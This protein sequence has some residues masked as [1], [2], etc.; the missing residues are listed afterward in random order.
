MGL[1]EYS[2]SREWRDE[3]MAVIDDGVGDG[4]ADTPLEYED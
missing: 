3:R 1:M 2:L 4:W